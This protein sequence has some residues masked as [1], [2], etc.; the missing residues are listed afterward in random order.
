MNC[1][2]WRLVTRLIQ[3][4]ESDG[5]LLLTVSIRQQVQ[6]LITSRS[7]IFDHTQASQSLFAIEEEGELHCIAEACSTCF[8]T[9]GNSPV[10]VTGRGQT[11]LSLAAKYGYE[12]WTNLLLNAGNVDADHRDA[13]G[14]TPL[15][16]AAY[17]GHARVVARLLERMD[18]DPNSKDSI[19]QTPLSWAAWCGHVEVVRVMVQCPSVDFVA[20]YDLGRTPLAWA[21]LNTHPEVARL[22]LRGFDSY[23]VT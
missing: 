8:V 4:I 12:G 19:G 18:V 1:P 6:R 13:N 7:V 23:V 17:H 15:S 21:V 11:V 14:Q 9:L 2:K 22:L 5:K 20:G 3:S 16:L 10:A